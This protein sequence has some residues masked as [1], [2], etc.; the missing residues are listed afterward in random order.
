MLSEEQIQAKF[1]AFEVEVKA[2]CAKYNVSLKAEHEFKL[3]TMWVCHTQPYP[4][5]DWNVCE[6]ETSLLQGDIIESLI[7]IE[8]DAE[9][10]EFVDNLRA[11]ELTNTTE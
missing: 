10:V 11:M 2:L 8:R 9:A 7:K 4:S 5:G 3:A 1:D 6:R